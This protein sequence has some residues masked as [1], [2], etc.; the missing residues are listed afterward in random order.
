[1]K[2]IQVLMSTYNGEK[3]V[4]EQIESILKQT[5]ENFEILIR[6]DGSKDNTKEVLKEYENNPKIN[7]IYG[8]NIG[9]IRSFL[10]LMNS[11]KKYDYYVLCDQDDYWYRNKLEIFIKNIVDEDKPLLYVSNYEVVSS[12]LSLIRQEYKTSHKVNISIKNSLIENPFPGCVYFYNNNLKEKFKNKK[13]NINNV[14]MHDYYIYMLATF[15]GDVKYIPD[16]LV[17]YRQHE[18]NVI[19][20]NSKRNILDNF[21]LSLKNVEKILAIKNQVRMIS[22]VFRDEINEKKLNIIKKYLN[23]ESVCQRII[24][25]IRYGLIKNKKNLYMKIRYII[26]KY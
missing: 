1:M 5:Y 10:F 7:I 3:Y 4:R 8:E 24:F 2:K 15:I 11:D 16:C 18:N 25:L 13:I 23:A 12:N 26:N 21:L 14:I 6:D 20:N 17:K 9:V 19:G 22:N